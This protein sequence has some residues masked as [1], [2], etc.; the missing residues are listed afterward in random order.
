MMA[1]GRRL[2]I[3]ARQGLCLPGD[4]DCHGDA[5]PNGLRSAQR[6]FQPGEN[7][8]EASEAR[9]RQNRRPQGYDAARP[10]TS[11]LE[12]DTNHADRLRVHNP[13]ASGRTSKGRL[14]VSVSRHM[15]A[16]IDGVIHDTHDRVEA[17]RAASTDTGNKESVRT[18][19]RW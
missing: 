8:K 13:P 16:V 10:G 15:V 18:R 6:E 12:V 2:A 19:G 9:E 17:E 5:L 3:E 11:R 4:S 7:Y 14:I 1:A